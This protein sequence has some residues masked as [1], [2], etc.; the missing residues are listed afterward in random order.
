MSVKIISEYLESLSFDWKERK[1]I[2]NKVAPHNEVK[3]K[4]LIEQGPTRV[5]IKYDGVR[6]E[7]VSEGNGTVTFFSRTGKELS[8]ISENLKDI[9]R[10]K[11]G[12][13]EAEVYSPNKE[14]SLETVSGIL[15]P[16][17]I[18]P[19]TEEQ[20]AVSEELTLAIFD[21]VPIKSFAEGSSSVAYDDRRRHLETIFNKDI[22]ALEEEVES[23]EGYMKFHQ[24]ALDN[25][26][27]GTVLKSTSSLWSGKVQPGF[28]KQ[29]RGVEYDL[30]CVGVE[31]GKGK[32]EGTVGRLGFKWRQGEILWM[33]G[34]I[35]DVDR[36]AMFD[37]WDTVLNKV[38]RITALTESS[39]GK[40]RLPKFR[41]M[42]IDKDKGDF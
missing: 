34:A 15:N 21:W 29:V 42:R 30:T 41:D 4:K 23:Y 12:V 32:R 18:K 5:S 11:E 20:E 17:R 39:K 2:V 9:F 28:I 26:E 24:A 37:D 14:T 16:K 38:F 25:G 13:F 33:D 40:L 8:C 35:N 27:E 22:L 36:Q 6:A 1:I 31:A 3:A 10:G 7:I 19:L